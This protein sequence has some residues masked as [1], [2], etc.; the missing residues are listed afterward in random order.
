MRR[1]LDIACFLFAAVLG[2]AGLG[3]L[4]FGGT[5]SNRI[6]EFLL[7][8]FAWGA[9]LALVR[10]GDPDFGK[11]DIPLQWSLIGAIWIIGGAAS[12]VHSV[13]N[14]RSD[15]QGRPEDDVVV[16]ATVKTT[17]DSINLEYLKG[18][19]QG[20]KLS[21]PAMVV[22]VGTGGLHPLHSGLRNDLV[23]WDQNEVETVIYI[24]STP[25]LDDTDPGLTIRFLNRVPV[26][27][28]VW[29]IS[30]AP[31]SRQP[32]IA[33]RQTFTGDKL[34]DWSKAGVLNVGTNKNGEVGVYSV[35]SASRPSLIDGAE[36]LF[37]DEIEGRAQQMSDG[38]FV[39][40][41]V[42]PGRW[43]EALDWI[44]DPQKWAEGTDTGAGSSL[45]KWLLWIVAL[46]GLLAWGFNDL[47][48]A[49]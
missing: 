2:F 48:T 44:M 33:Y 43:D 27:K 5:L 35:P 6:D 32:V 11:T 47:R 24:E 22:D 26:Y 39:V 37:A 15:L 8:L 45:I 28:S 42:G 34:E 4:V 18:P 29:N 36:I 13:L 19:V 38:R 23:A 10:V 20:R 46:G 17:L 25:V 7:V 1:L 3:V 16:N 14:V 31:V 49:S 30:M 40:G 21:A 12:G 41:I 9:A